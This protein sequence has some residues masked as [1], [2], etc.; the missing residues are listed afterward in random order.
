MSPLLARID[1]LPLIIFAVVVAAQVAAAVWKKL[2]QE[3]ETDEAGKQEGDPILR[4]LGENLLG[5]P[6]PSIPPIDPFMPLTDEERRA[7]LERQLRGGGNWRGAPPPPLESSPESEASR[8]LEPAPTL[9]NWVTFD[10]AAAAMRDAQ[11]RLA[12]AD[13]LATETPPS[14]REAPAALEEATTRIWA[15]GQAVDHPEAPRGAI[16]TAHHPNA[17]VAR[18]MARS[19]REP[20]T[21]RGAVIAAI[22]LGRPKALED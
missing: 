1:T 10:D 14:F 4:R 8:E 11:E 19:F 9:E 5:M 12:R 3:I 22:L 21:A 18:E 17:G 16:S 6:R 15:G 7:R 13:A 2:R 20:A